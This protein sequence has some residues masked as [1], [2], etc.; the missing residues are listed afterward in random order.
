MTLLNQFT[1]SR[2][3]VICL[4]DIDRPIGGVKQLFKHVEHLSDLGLDAAMVTESPTFHPSWFTSNAPVKSWLQCVEDGE[5]SDSSTI[6]VLPETYINVDLYNFNGINISSLKRIIFNQNAY[7]SFGTSLATPQQIKDFYCS[8]N[9]LH[10]LC[11]SSDSYNFLTSCLSLQ[12]SKVS[13]IINAIEPYFIP[14]K[15]KSNTFCFMPRKNSDHVH[16]ILTSLQL[17]STAFPTR[18]TGQPLVDLTHTTIAE[19]LSTSRLF[20]SFGHP[21]GFGLPVA[22]A[23]ASGCWVV[24]YSGLGGSELFSLNGSSV[25]EFGNWTDFI[26]KIHDVVIRFHLHREETELILDHQSQSIREIYS[27][28]NEVK[29]IESAWLKIL[30]LQSNH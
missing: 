28:A 15:T 14:Q 4:P 6:L 9:V 2:V 11:V 25:V 17:S 26:H 20:L 23:M 29:S 5:F 3:R 30:S 8:E 12:P 7:Y 16:S 22:E 18:W 24:G 27:Y 19:F 10:T 1:L 13:R 21:E